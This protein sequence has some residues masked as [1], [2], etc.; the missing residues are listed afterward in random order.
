MKKSFYLKYLEDKKKAEKR[1]DEK[2]KTSSLFILLFKTIKKIIQF[3]LYILLMAIVS[4]GLT[5]LVNAQIRQIFIDV[6]F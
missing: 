5:S 6:L 2:S 3:I 1:L 4:I